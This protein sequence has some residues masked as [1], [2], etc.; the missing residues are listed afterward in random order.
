[1]LKLSGAYLLLAL[2]N[3]SEL[4]MKQFPD[5]QVCEQQAQN[6]RAQQRFSV[7]QCFHNPTIAT[8]GATTNR[9]A[10]EIMGEA[11]LELFAQ[12]MRSQR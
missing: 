5:M 3:G 8:G 12:F 6:Y 9:Q 10:A 2:A 4:G 11:M 1:M 7:V